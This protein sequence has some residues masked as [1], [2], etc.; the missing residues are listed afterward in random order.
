[1]LRVLKNLSKPVCSSPQDMATMRSRLIQNLLGAF[2]ANLD[3]PK[4]NIAP[5]GGTSGSSML[6]PD[7]GRPEV[8]RCIML[9][10][11]PHNGKIFLKFVQ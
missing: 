3:L 2:S 7:V 9:K 10:I 6:L 1:M 4:V 8:G 5:L 11:S